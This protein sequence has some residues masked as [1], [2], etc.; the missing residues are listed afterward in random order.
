MW[1]FFTL[2]VNLLELIFLHKLIDHILQLLIYLPLDT[3]FYAVPWLLVS[4]P[5][6]DIR[7]I[8]IN[9][10]W[11]SLPK[12]KESICNINTFKSR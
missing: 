1:V 3:L 8:T 10:T 2:N 5:V 7:V 6:L 12:L 4:A 9:R 11:F